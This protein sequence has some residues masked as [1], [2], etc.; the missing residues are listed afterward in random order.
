MTGPL[1]L[2]AVLSLGGGFINV[3][4]W[5]EP[6]FPEKAENQALAWL[7]AG[8]GLLGILIAYLFYVKRP[9]LADSFARSVG[10]LYRLVYNK[11]FV[12]EI[13]GAAVVTPVVKGSRFFLWRGVDAGFIDGIVNGIGARSR[14]VG[15]ILRLL[16]SGNIRS[17]A[18]WVVLGSVL[19]LL[20][21]GFG[22]T[23]R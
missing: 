2:L 8:V 10:G 16:Q 13:Y 9:G 3:P 19:L 1:M 6:L 14:G 18:A 23:A 4:H 20:A 22:G 11:Y 7:S 21:I 12:D 17:Y 5:L 15:A